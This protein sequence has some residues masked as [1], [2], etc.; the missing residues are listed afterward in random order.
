MSAVHDGYLLTQSVQRQPLGG[1]LLNACLQ[2]SLEAQGVSLH[3]IYSFKKTLGEGPPSIAYLDLPYTSA[4]F[5][6]FHVESV[7]QD[8]KEQVGPGLQRVWCQ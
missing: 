4:S 7:V 8:L 6:R 2:A 5:K 3:P 1:R